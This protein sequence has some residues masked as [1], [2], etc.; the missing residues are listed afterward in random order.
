MY[1]QRLRRY[2]SSGDMRWN[3]GLLLLTEVSES[4]WPHPVPRLATMQNAAA[5]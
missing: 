5:M 4:S 3:G 2:C 1:E